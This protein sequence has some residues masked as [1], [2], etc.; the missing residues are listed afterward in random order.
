MAQKKERAEDSPFEAWFSW[1]VPNKG[2]VWIDQ[3]NPAFNTEPKGQPPYLIKNP[4]GEIETKKFPLRDS[5]DLFSDFEALEPTREHVL[6]F[7][8][9]YG[10]LGI[11]DPLYTDKGSVLFHGEGL[12]LWRNEIV[13]IQ[14][15]SRVSEWIDSQNE[16]ELA[17]RIEW[18]PSRDG[19]RFNWASIGREP[20]NPI[21]YTDRRRIERL[22]KL[23]ERG[24]VRHDYIA[25]KNFNPELLTIWTP[26][27]VLGP[28]NAWL[29]RQINKNV[30]GRVWVGLILDQ[31]GEKQP[32]MHAENLLAAIWY[33][34]YGS[35]IGEKKLV[36]C[37]VCKRWM[38]ATKNRRSKRMHSQC[39]MWLRNQRRT[40]R[41]GKK[42]GKKKTR[43]KRR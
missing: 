13:N 27:D 11:G 41:K 24:F 15:C 14:I 5:P 34:F 42:N 39:S 29:V 4:D 26:G 32:V 38:D 17:T 31:N 3:A 33:Q 36:R 7:A 22:A 12:N 40:E 25:G 18:T 1:W 9:R 6:E 2:Y 35:V 19:V 43:T 8:N 21:L 23:T 10:W 30:H 20:I 16:S 37:E 28:A